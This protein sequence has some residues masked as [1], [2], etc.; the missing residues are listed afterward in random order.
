MKN[1]YSFI[2]IALVLTVVSV[3]FVPGLDDLVERTFQQYLGQ[4]A[5]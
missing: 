3:W 4:A 1:F 5:R 2:A